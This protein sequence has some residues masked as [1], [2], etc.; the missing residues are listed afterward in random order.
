VKPERNIARC[1]ADSSRRPAGLQACA[2]APAG[3]SLIELLIVIALILILTTMYWSSGS[4]SRQRQ[5]QGACQQNLQKIFVALQIYANDHAGRF[6]EGAGAR[7]SEEALD[8]L[9]PRYTVDTPVFICPGSK[10]APLPAGESFRQRKISYAY[11]TGRCLTDT[12]AVLMSDRQ[13]DARAKEAGQYVFSSTGK[14]PGNNHAKRGGNFLFGDGHAESS[15][16]QLPFSLVLTQ[17]V[18]LLNPKP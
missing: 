9:V 4:P 5:Q 14:P 7:T 10:D 6:P 17:G 1:S 15:P 18:L 13:V 2:T 11:Y 16:A 3:F 8:V 12:Q